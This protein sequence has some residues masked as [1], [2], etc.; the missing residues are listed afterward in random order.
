MPIINISPIKDK[1]LFYFQSGIKRK[2]HAIKVVYGIWIHYNEAML[3]ATKEN[4][5]HSEQNL[6]Q[7]NSIVY[8]YYKTLN[9]LLNK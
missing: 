1:F 4:T 6:P 5:I 2:G 7:T 8:A 9:K 3:K